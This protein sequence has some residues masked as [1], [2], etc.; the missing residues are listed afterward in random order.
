VLLGLARLRFDVEVFDLLP[1]DLRAVQGLKLYQEHFANARE[2]IIAVKAENP[3]QSETAARKIAEELRRLTNLV[4]SV[5]WEPPWLEHPD[6]SAEFLA[7]LWLNQP[8]QALAELTNRLAPQNLVSILTSTRDELATSMSPEAIARLSYDPFGLTRLPESVSTASPSFAQGQEMFSSKD[9]RLRLLFVGSRSDLRTYDECG[10]WLNQVKQTATSVLASDTQLSGVSLGYTGRPAFYSEVASGMQHDITTSVGGT[11]A[12]IAVLFWIAHR[13]VKPM[14]W[15]LALLTAILGSTLALGGLIYGTINVVSMG[16]AAILLGLA[17]DYAVVHYQE[18]LAHPTLSI[19]QI[20]HAIAPSIFWAAVTTITAFLVLNLGGL[21]GLDQLGTLVGLGVAL[22]A[23]IMIFE[24][25]P[26]LFPGRNEPP[27]TFRLNS[28]KESVSDG[29]AQSTHAD[30]GKHL[31]AMRRRSVGRLRVLVVLAVT[32]LAVVSTGLVVLFGRPPID[33]TANALRPRKSQAYST[34]DEIQSALNQKQEPL[35]LIVKGQT[36]SDVANTLEG[37]EATLKRAASNGVLSGFSLPAVIW[38][39]PEFQTENRIAAQD[40]VRERQILHETAQT[41]GFAHSS[42]VLTDGMLDTWEQASRAPGVFWPTNQMSEWILQKVTARTPSNYFALGLLNSTSGGQNSKALEKMEALDSQLPREDVWLSGWQLLGNAI[43]SRVKANMWKVIIPM[44]LLVFLSLYFAF[45]RPAEILLSL[46]VLFLSAL[47]LLSIMRAAGWKWNLLNLMAIPLVLGTGVDYSIFMQL[48]LRRYKGDL[49]MAYNSVGRA[50]L[51]CGGTAIAGFGSLAWSS[52]AGMASLGQVCAVGIGSNMLIAI[53]LLPIWWDRIVNRLD[54]KTISLKLATASSELTTPSSLYSSSFWRLGMWSVRL[55]PLWLSQKLSTLAV[56]V[57]LRLAPHRREVVTKNLLPALRGDRSAAQRTA[58]ALFRQF[59]LKLI[60]LWRFEGGQKVDDLLGKATGWE[61]FLNAKDQKRGVLLLTPHLGNWEFGGPLMTQRG[62]TLQVLTLAEPGTD[63][64][65]LRQA[66]R[67][68]WK[69]ETLVVGSDPLAF[70]EVIRRLES[71]ATV[72]LLVDRPPPAS[73]VLVELFGKAFSASIAA[74]ELAR[75]S[76][77]VLLPVYL[78]REGNRYSAHIL[79]A[80]PYERAALRDRETRRRLTQ[81][82]V[83]TFEPL[84]ERHL[85]QW[86][87]FVSV[88]PTRE[89][90][91]EKT[92]E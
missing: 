78:P 53:F 63:F 52:N 33:P 75:A 60:D 8:P 20:R 69:I 56:E 1:T 45:R 89:A 55:L 36:V 70:V 51:L 11:A 22:A 83:S 26:P 59:G 49:G 13:R 42:L 46:A 61:N 39:R 64:T 17:V 2:L 54:G 91:S 71:G 10:M 38:P 30:A 65:E 6:Q 27:G 50:L 74:A 43:F 40:L 18:A 31:D 73:A 58:K 90:E 44:V 29:M 28:A 41:N 5:V 85:D 81:L 80:I 47:C 4:S 24:F 16:F 32:A 19:P 87:H 77:C 9:G 82:I 23:L 67:A 86:Y 76:G 35:W 34:L 12:I 57:Y 7:F 72:A 21:P 88:W 92:L 48:A 37:L 3:E 84:I 62:E 14:L 25:L 66:S 15:L 68:R 79:P